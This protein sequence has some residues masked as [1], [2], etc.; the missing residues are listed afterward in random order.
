LDNVTDFD[1]IA[2]TLEKAIDIEALLKG[3]E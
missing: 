2:D 1:S 3:I